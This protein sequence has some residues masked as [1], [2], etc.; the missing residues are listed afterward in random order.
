MNNST[1]NN[2]F[3]E[4]LKQAL[5]STEKVISEN[6][7][8]KKNSD[9]NKNLKELS[10]LNFENLKTKRDFIKARADSDSSALKK[11]FLIMIFL[12]KIYL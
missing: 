5:A 6:F 12:K 7:E 11:N 8:V 3:K 4:K 1:K 9:Q 10:F 2:N